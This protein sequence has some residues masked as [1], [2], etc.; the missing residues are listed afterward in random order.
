MS[1]SL[2]RVSVS[3]FIGMEISLHVQSVGLA[4]PTGCFLKLIATLFC[5]M[6]ERYT[7]VP[8]YF[9]GGPALPSPFVVFP[10]VQ[11]DF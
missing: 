4:R 2:V 10:F 9:K 1:D 8:V 11:T 7:D 5:W 6:S 3:I